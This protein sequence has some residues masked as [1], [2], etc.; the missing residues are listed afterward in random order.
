ME[1]SQKIIAS[2]LIA[3]FALSA[4]AESD[5]DKNRKPALIEQVV[6]L[7]KK[8]CDMSEPTPRDSSYERRLR[9]VLQN[10]ESETLDVFVNKN[11]AV[12]L[13]HRLPEQKSGFWTRNSRH[14]LQP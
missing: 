9:T 6:D 13:D 7:T 12:C 10:T 1:H 4:C 11:I 2:T 14:L 5:F 3:A 8:T